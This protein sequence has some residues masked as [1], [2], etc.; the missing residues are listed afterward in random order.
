MGRSL[1]VRISRKLTPQATKASQRVRP[2]KLETRSVP[3]LAPAAGQ[4]F[5]EKRAKELPGCLEIELYGNWQ[6]HWSNT[7]PQGRGRY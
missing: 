5:D 2:A 1:P 6:D 7:L 4:G 3:I